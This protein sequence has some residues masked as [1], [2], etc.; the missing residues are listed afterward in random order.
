MTTDC[1]SLPPIFS[2]Q[3]FF[4]DAPKQPR[5]TCFVLN[6]DFQLA[7]AEIARL[8]RENKQLRE[9]KR[10]A[11]IQA[12]AGKKAAPRNHG[13]NLVGDFDAIVNALRLGDD[14]AGKP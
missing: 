2:P 12:E 3:R 4:L 8:Q 7:M 10:M 11:L 6:T 9:N 13:R 1:E 5:G 14:V